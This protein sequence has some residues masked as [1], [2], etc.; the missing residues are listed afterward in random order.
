MRSVEIAFA[1]VAIIGA[2]RLVTVELRES[3]SP[4]IDRRYAGLTERIGLRAKVGY[5]GESSV[6]TLEGQRR[7]SQASYALAPRLLLPDDGTAALVLV[8]LDQA[9]RTQTLAA[10]KRMTILLTLPSG[11]A[12]VERRVPDSAHSDVNTQDTPSNIRH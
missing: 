7:F 9:S 10:Q 12:L 11:G 5:V 4:P 6:E 2:G 1:L 8:D 3:K